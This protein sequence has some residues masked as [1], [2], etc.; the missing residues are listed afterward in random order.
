MNETPEG[1][2]PIEHESSGEV[3]STL[4]G[5]TDEQLEERMAGEHDP[6]TLRGLTAEAIKRMKEYRRLSE[7]DKLTEL[8]NREG[9][10]KHSLDGL[11]HAVRA[12]EP[13]CV[14][15][16]DIDF[17]KR[18]ND[19]YGHD[20]GDLTLQEASIIVQETIR[21]SDVAA[22]L[23]GEEIAILLPDTNLENAL[24]VAD[25]IRLG[26]EQQLFKRVQQK[27]NIEQN[28]QV[29]FTA[30]IGVFEIG[31]DL[32]NQLATSK[33]RNARLEIY[34]QALKRADQGLYQAKETGKN[35][36]IAMGKSIE[37]LNSNT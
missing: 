29:P 20:V 21:H 22:R 28:S 19:T 36:V 23:G 25:R 8:Y 7:R 12:N 37:K 18:V 31:N 10:E 24:L 11:D 34:N 32:K 9:F 15:M 16:L 17:F 5:L 13:V 14:M 27:I 30:S 26:F 33:D 35:Q 2:P 3:V 4:A 1:Y 6:E